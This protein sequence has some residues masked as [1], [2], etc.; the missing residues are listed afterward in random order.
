M[1]EGL[2]DAAGA[3]RDA[4]REAGTYKRFNTLRSP[5]GPVVEME[6]RG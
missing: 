1:N 5:Q 3:E 2:H 6:G 4:L